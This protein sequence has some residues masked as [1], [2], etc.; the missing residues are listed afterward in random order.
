MLEQWQLDRPT[1]SDMVD[2]CTEG[3]YIM[4]NYIVQTLRSDD[5]LFE[6]Y[7]GSEVEYYDED[8]NEI[9]YSE[10]ID[11]W[12]NGENVR[13]EYAEIFQYFII[14]ANAAEYF[15][16]YT[17]QLVLYNEETGIYLLCVQH[18][19]TSWDYCPADWKEQEN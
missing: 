1:Y 5:Y 7:C 15:R 3:R 11:R 16:R 6:P 12:N 10:Y 18:W 19:G 13:E 8:G 2:Y 9:D 14:T 17:N 4:N